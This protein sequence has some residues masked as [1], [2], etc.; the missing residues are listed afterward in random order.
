M[1]IEKVDILENK[2]LLIDKSLL[3]ILLSDRTTSKNILWCTDNYSNYG[4]G[5]SYIEQIRIE[6]ITGKKGNV[7]KPRVRKTKKEQKSRV[8]EKAEVF[9]S[10]WACNHQNNH[11]DSIWFGRDNVFNIEIDNSWE[12]IYEKIN[13]ES[14]DKTWIDYVND[15]RLEV[16]CGEAPYIVSRYDT[17]TGIIIDPKDRIGILDRKIRII[18]ENADNDEWFFW[19]KK[20]Y[21]S[22]YGYEWQGDSLLIARENLLYSFID[23]Y[24]ERFKSLPSI[25]QQIEIADIISWNFW[26]MDGLKGV[27]PLSCDNEKVIQVNLFGEDVTVQCEGCRQANI[28]KHN[29]IYCR[30]KEWTDNKGKSKTHRY[31]DL[32]DK[33]VI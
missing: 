18:N 30:I 15:K 14:K 4:L 1:D 13:F 22:V 20:A 10:S 11:I 33:G 8:K 2:I 19:V 16:S 29:G 5:Y 21:Q 25:Q 3:E 27:V 31:I 9:T 32:F 26:Q 12:V 7:I 23:Y 24:Y 17:V 28:N 6:L